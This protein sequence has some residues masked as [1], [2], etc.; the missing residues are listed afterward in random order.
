MRQV[1]NTYLHYLLQIVSP[2]PCHVPLWVRELFILSMIGLLAISALD[3]CLDNVQLQKLQS[4]V[5]ACR[6]DTDY[7]LL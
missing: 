2:S 7:I 4:S 5:H 6:K 3:V 1:I